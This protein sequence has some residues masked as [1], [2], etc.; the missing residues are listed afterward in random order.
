[1]GFESTCNSE[2]RSSKPGDIVCGRKK[3]DGRC[4]AATAINHMHEKP[5]R[6][7]GNLRPG[8]RMTCLCHEKAQQRGV[9]A[10]N[11][12]GELQP[13]RRRMFVSNY[14]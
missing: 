9:R 4:F 6:P 11:D 7:H 5:E 13:G 2:S 10:N 3:M 14:A 8:V 1:M 12:V